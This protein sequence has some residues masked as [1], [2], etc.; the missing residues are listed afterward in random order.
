M[1]EIIRRARKG[2]TPLVVLAI[3]SF[4]LAIVSA[5]GL[6]FDDRVLLGQPIWLKP[7][8]FGISFAVYALTLA[9]LMSHLTRGHR[10][11]RVS[12]WAV[13]VASV[14]ELAIIT[15]Q[16]GRGRAS[17]FNTSTELDEMLWA[18]MGMTIVVL[19]VATAVIAALLWKAG[20]PDR[21]TQWAVR[22]GLVIALVGLTEGFLMTSTTDAQ[23]GSDSGYD[24]AHSVGVADG[25]KGMPLTGWSMEGGDLR[26][27]HFVGMHALQAL[28]LFSLFVK[29]V[30]MVFVFAAAYTGLFAL[31]TWQALRGQPL[32]APDATTLIALAGLVIFAVAGAV[33]AARRR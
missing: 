31:V 28:L 17:H 18:A 15:T 7:F 32:L 11:A 25:G 20:L 27:G 12:A 6:L 24:G 2:S 13:S 1:T 33:L 3:A 26:I 8:K 29:Q 10:T 9:W 22:L 30:R 5:A 14:I 23:A 16:V 19:W 4:C 21:A